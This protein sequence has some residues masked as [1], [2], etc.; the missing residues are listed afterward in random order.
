M[1]ND[2]WKRQQDQ[3]TRASAKVLE[4]LQRSPGINPSNAVAV[5]QVAIGRICSRYL[6]ESPDA[7]SAFASL[8]ATAMRAMFD[9]GFD[10][11]RST[12]GN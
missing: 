9:L 5:L 11:E 7:E 8:P 10:G 6:V 3:I 4:L 2:E 1:T 12:R